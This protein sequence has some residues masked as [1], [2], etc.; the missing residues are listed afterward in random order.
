MKRAV[1]LGGGMVGSCMAWDLRTHGGL[2]VTVADHRPAALA[3]V[4]E[5]FGVK[6]LQAN[7]ADP[8]EVQRA[9]AESDIVLGALSSAIGFP[10]LQ[11]VIEAGKTYVDISF[12]A[13]PVTSRSCGSCGT[14]GCSRK[15]ASKLT[16]RKSAR[17]M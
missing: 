16:A 8:A 17:W 2:E 4:A 15:R 9:V 10:T 5:K 3:R 1:V 7:L 13:I 11:A 6:T 14:R 12:M